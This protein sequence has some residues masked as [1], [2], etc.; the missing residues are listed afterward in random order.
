MHRRLIYCAQ[1]TFITVYGTNIYRNK[2]DFTDQLITKLIEEF[3]GTML[4]VISSL[5]NRFHSI[6]SFSFRAFG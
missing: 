4:N 2:N 5:G 3:Y 1:Y 6:V